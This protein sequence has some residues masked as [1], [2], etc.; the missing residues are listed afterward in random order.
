MQVL[1]ETR[2]PKALV[3]RG[4]A[5]RRTRF[6]MRRLQWMV[7]RARVYMDDVNGPHGGVDKRCRI[8]LR[9]AAG[10]P[11]VVTSMATSWRR[12]LEAALARAARALL[13]WWQRQHQR[14]RP[15]PERTLPLQ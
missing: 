8:E 3:L 15:A 9:A 14:A 13:R 11:V 6:V 1:F 10:E 4:L 2:S 7:P 12:A 5:V